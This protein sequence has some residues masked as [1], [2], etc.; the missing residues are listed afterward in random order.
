MK[1]LDTSNERYMIDARPLFSSVWLALYC[2]LR[3]TYT[4][5]QTEAHALTRRFK[6][7]P[8]KQAD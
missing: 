2:E 3:R 1:Q 7:F 5:R 4:A 8:K 6:A